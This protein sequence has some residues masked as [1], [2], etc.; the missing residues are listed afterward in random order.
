MFPFILEVNKTIMVLAHL[1]YPLF[2]QEMK[3]INL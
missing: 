3:E 1:P 2:M